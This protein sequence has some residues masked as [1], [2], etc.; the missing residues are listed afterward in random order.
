MKVEIKFKCK[1]QL[2]QKFIFLREINFIN[3][4]LFLRLFYFGLFYVMYLVALLFLFK[5][6]IQRRDAL[7]LLDLKYSQITP[8]GL[9]LEFLLK[10]SVLWENKTTEDEPF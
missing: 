2:M 1:H 6:K 9:C 3:L 4:L 10:L 5:N 8:K 7:S